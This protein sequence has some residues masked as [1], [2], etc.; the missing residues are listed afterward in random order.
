MVSRLLLFLR[1]LPL[2]LLVLFVAS[3]LVG[4]TPRLNV[5]PLATL[6]IRIMSSPTTRHA[7]CRIN[8]VPHFYGNNAMLYYP[9][10]VLLRVFATFHLDVLKIANFSLIDERRKP[11]RLWR[12]GYKNSHS[13]EE[14]RDVSRWPAH[15]FIRPKLDIYECSPT[16]LSYFWNDFDIL[17]RYATYIYPSSSVYNT[18]QAIL[19]E[20]SGNL[21]C[22]LLYFIF[23]IGNVTRGVVLEQ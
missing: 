18:S 7:P 3:F 11:L 19:D 13:W 15:F 21:K 2:S 16:P 10:L 5:Y 14:S 12:N 8:R 17:F 1:L 9:G 6:R 20:R 23:C 22:G 4:R